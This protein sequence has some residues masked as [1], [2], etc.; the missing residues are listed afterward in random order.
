MTKY[1]IDD[2]EVDESDFYQEL[3]DIITEYVDDNYDDLLD[4]MYPKYE[5]GNISFCASRILKELDPIAYGCMFDGFVDS[6][7]TEA[8][9]QLEK[10]GGIYDSGKKIFNIVEVED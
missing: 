4:D 7:L 3:E 9:Y 8:K 6:E 5:I 2:E 1:L 10:C